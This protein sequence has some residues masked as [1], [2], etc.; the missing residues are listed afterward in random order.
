MSL[1]GKGNKEAFTGATVYGISILF[2]THLWNLRIIYVIRRVGL[3]TLSSTKVW[4]Q[5]HVGLYTHM[6]VLTNGRDFPSR[7]LSSN[8]SF[9]ANGG[10]NRNNYDYNSACRGGPGGGG[11]GGVLLALSRAFASSQVDQ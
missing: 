3:D 5:T 2:T 1:F 4:A 10:V 7:G 6:S 9:R 11:R 8:P